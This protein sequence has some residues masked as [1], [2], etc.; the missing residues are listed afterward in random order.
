MLPRNQQNSY[1]FDLVKLSATKNIL[2]SK[3]SSSHADLETHSV[4]KPNSVSGSVADRI[5]MFLGLLDPAPDPLVRDKDP[6]P[7]RILLL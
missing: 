1:Y 3:W 6:D 7:A 5:W 4:P 2:A